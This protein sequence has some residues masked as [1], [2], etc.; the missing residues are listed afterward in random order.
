LPTAFTPTD[1]LAAII[2]LLRPQTIDSK[3]VTAAGQ[4]GVRYERQGAPG[5]CVVLEG[6][7]FLDVDGIGVLE[8]RAGD[9]VLLTETPSFTM[10]SDLRVRPTHVSPDHSPEVR[11]GART[12]PVTMRMLG[13]YFR[14]DPPNAQLLVRLLPAFVHVRRDDAGAARLRR[15]VEQIGDEAA[16]RRAGRELVL[17]RLVEVLLVE[18]LRLLP[19]SGGEHQGGLL[20]GLA[21]AALARPLRGIHADLT[22]R[23]SVAALARAAGMSRAVFAERFARTVGIPPMQYLLELRMAMAREVLRRERP[24]L[25]EV[26]ERVGYQSASAF[27]AAF[28]RSMGCSPSEFVRTLG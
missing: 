26:A 15:V 27:S 14:F 28:S 17:E 18:A 1:P 3:V 11:H 2:G 21:D 5:F 4:W 25:A 10:A 13:G 9:F 22:R 24:P 12:G 16:A 6:S 20:A 7:F 23:W 8:V 19:A